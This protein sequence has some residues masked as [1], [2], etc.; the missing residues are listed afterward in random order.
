MAYQRLGRLDEA[1]AD[2]DRAI[3]VQGPTSEALNNRGCLQRDR[4]D[5]ERAL[6]DV[7]EAVRLAPGDAVALVSLAEVRTARSEWEAALSALE[8][9]VE[10]DV[11]WRAHARAAEA[12]A[13]LRAARPEAAVF[14]G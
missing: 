6:A 3:A 9:G 7:E 2:Y 13:P 14:G 8:R 12:F 10:I 5:L 11:A 1:L 4:G